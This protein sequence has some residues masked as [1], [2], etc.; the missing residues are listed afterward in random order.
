MQNPLYMKAIVFEYNMK[1]FA[2]SY[3]LGRINRK[4]YFTKYG[5]MK[6]TEHPDPPLFGD[7]WVTIRTEY[8]G[9]CGSD[10]KQAFLEGNLDNPM[11]GL[12]SYPHVLGH[13]VV[14]IIAKIGSNVKRVKVGDRVT[15]YSNLCCIPRGLE[16]CSACDEG[17]FSLCR[18]LT[19]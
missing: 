11:T 9:I 14:G 7:D 19:E 4:L 12:I 17:D 10:F 5:H 2:L 15:L 8:C 13:E 1:K 6:V 3:V 16:P 18:N